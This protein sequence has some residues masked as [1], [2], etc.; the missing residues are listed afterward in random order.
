MTAAPGYE[1]DLTSLTFNYA[2]QNNHNQTAHLASSLDSYG[3]VIGTAAASFNSSYPLRTI[4]LSGVEFQDL[5]SITFRL[6]L[7][8]DNGSSSRGHYVDNLVLSGDVTLIPEP[9]SLALLGLGG[10]C[11]LSRRRSA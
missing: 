4:D 11:M 5:G 8:D 7:T 6:S 3:S 2:F 1:L 9:A 10:L